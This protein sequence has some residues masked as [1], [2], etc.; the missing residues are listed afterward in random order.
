[1]SLFSLE[2]KEA[3]LSRPRILRRCR[4]YIHS[5]IFFHA[6]FLPSRFYCSEIFRLLYPEET[7]LFIILS[8][9]HA[10]PSHHLELLEIIQANCTWSPPPPPRYVTVLTLLLVCHP[11]YLTFHAFLYL[12]CAKLTLLTGLVY[13]KQDTSLILS[14]SLR[15]VSSQTLC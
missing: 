4:I 3:D 10:T 9:R 14:V 15:F 7:I 12:L 8:S 6:F 13:A 1:M 11:S 5:N 2:S